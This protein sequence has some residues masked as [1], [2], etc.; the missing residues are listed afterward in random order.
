MA[1]TP[2]PAQGNEEL[3]AAI[4]ERDTQ[5]TAANERLARMEETLN[6]VARPPQQ[7]QGPP[8]LPPGKRYAIPEN[9][10]QQ[11]AGFGLSD[12]EIE[13]NG[14]LIVPFLQAYI[15]Q[16]AAEVLSIIR[17]Q[18]DDIQQLHMLR[19][20]D[21]YPHADQLFNEITKVR[22]AE[23]QQGRYIPPDVAYRIAVA[24]NYEKIAGAGSATEG[25]APGGQFGGQ[26]SAPPPTPA[27]VR[28]RDASAA[29]SLRG[30]RAPTTEPQRPIS[31]ADDLMSMSRE[32]RK[33]FF[34]QNGETP[35][36]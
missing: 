36:R 7:P 22:R 5:I 34:A 18:A 3:L 21:Q 15:G 20:M 1:D 11:I 9:L 17:S 4:R 6:A 32:E 30:V 16:A 14:D 24:N 25:G 2:A 8:P 28:S 13:K 23:I 19:D 12:A 33:S 31:K 10:R 29:G 27:A 35:I 26:P